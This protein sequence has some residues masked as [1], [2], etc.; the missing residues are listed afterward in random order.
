[1]RFDFYIPKLKLCI[2]FDGEQHF[3]IKTIWGGK[4]AFKYTKTNDKIKN[5]YCV[6]NKINLLRIP[7]TKLKEVELILKP[8]IDQYYN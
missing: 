5:R 3:K 8:I 7:Y 4:K 2:E 1:M 6:E